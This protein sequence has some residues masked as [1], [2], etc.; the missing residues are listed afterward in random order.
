MAFKI[1]AYVQA[2][3]IL[4]LTAPRETPAPSRALLPPIPLSNLGALGV[5]GGAESAITWQP[6]LVGGGG[7]D[8][9]GWG[10][11]G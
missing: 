7:L 4:T 2:A 8:K 9:G 1:Q 3:V 10:G 5:G 11:G 6:S